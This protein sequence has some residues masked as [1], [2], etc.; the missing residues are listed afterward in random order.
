MTFVSRLS[1]FIRSFKRPVYDA[2]GLRVSGKNVP[3]LS[4][5]RF[6]AAYRAGIN[7]GHRFGDVHIEWRVAVACWAASNAMRLPGD[8]VECGVNTGI[9]SLAI[10][11][12]VDFNASAKRFWLFDT[13][14]GIPEEQALAGEAQVDAMNRK[15]RDMYEVAV[16]NFAPFPRACLV[17]GRVPDTLAAQPIERVAYLHL[18]MNIAYPERAALEFFWPKL[19]QGAFVLLDDYAWKGYDAQMRSADEFARSQGVEILAL[20]TGQGMLVKPPANASDSCRTG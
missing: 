1:Q 5:E 15:Y 10:C 2:D 17:R 11:N 16:R 4:N 8:F 3:F 7:S 14:D 6:M 12:Y 18:D 9:L 20:P 19:V 13:F